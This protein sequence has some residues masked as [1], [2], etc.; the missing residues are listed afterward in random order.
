LDV[1]P[2]FA[3]SGARM[4]NKGPAKESRNKMRR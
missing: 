2:R 4:E 1:A 3:V